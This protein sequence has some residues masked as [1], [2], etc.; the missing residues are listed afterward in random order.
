MG[1]PTLFFAI[2]CILGGVASAVVFHVILYYVQGSF[3]KMWEIGV[4]VN[5]IVALVV[6]I[7]IGLLMRRLLLKNTAQSDQP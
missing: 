6:S 4:I 7:V 5:A 1:D 3:S 2:A